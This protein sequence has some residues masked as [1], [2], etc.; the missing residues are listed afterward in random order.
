M[1]INHSSLVRVISLQSTSVQPYYWLFNIL[2]KSY[3][4]SLNLFESCSCR[5]LPLKRISKRFLCSDFFPPS[6]RFNFN[7]NNL[8]NNNNKHQPLA[9]MNIMPLASQ[10][11]CFHTFN[12]NFV[13]TSKYRIFFLP[14][15]ISEA[16]THSIVEIR[17]WNGFCEKKI[18]KSSSNDWNIGS[19]FRRMK[20][21][22]NKTKTNKKQITE[23]Q[24]MEWH[25]N[26][27][28]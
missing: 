10:S 22:A 6:I 24:M 28:N 15:R 11:N 26:H 21:N 14:S 17:V 5:V 12:D 9:T 23:I 8:N 3:K 1:T 13:F 4:W 27:S 16:Q 25:G 18:K 20:G 7:N 19:R 2:H